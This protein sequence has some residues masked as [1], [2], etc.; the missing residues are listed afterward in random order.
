MFFFDTCNAVAAREGHRHLGLS[1]TL[2]QRQTQSASDCVMLLDSQTRSG[3]NK[4]QGNQ[5]S[6]VIFKMSRLSVT[7]QRQTQSKMA[8]P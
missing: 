1:L 8:A 2:S 3:F 5:Q 7:S 6:Q 4:E